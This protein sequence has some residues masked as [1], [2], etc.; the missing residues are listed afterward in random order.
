MENGK[1]KGNDGKKNHD[2]RKAAGNNSVPS[3]KPHYCVPF[4][5]LEGILNISENFKM[6][7]MENKK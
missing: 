4:F 7:I 2:L 1:G 6:S 5:S 3:N